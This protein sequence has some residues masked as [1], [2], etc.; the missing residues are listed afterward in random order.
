MLKQKFAVISL[1]IVWKS[2]SPFSHDRPHNSQRPSAATSSLPTTTCSHHRHSPAIP[3]L[4]PPTTTLL[5]PMTRQD[6]ARMAKM[7]P[8]TRHVTRPMCN[9]P[10]WPEEA[11][12]RHTGP[13]KGWGRVRG[14]REGMWVGRI[15]CAR[16][17]SS[18]FTTLLTIPTEP[19]PLRQT[20][21]FGTPSACVSTWRGGFWPPPTPPCIETQDGGF[22]HPPS[23]LRLAF[24]PPPALPRI[25]M[26]EGP[27]SLQ[28][29]DGGG[30]LLCHHHPVPLPRLKC[31][32][33]GCC[34]LRLMFWWEGGF[35]TPP[36]SLPRSKHGTDRCRIPLRLAFRCEGGVW[37]I[38]GPASK[39]DRRG[40]VSPSVSCFDARE[41]FGPPHYGPILIPVHTW[42]PLYAAFLLLYC[43]NSNN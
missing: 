30:V 2:L 11:K 1:R 39:H 19:F 41:V 29:Q 37:T 3:C 28:T 33:E 23:T 15:R 26:Q 17:F 42:V 22:P 5:R 36:L 8:P 13:Q 14:T 25:K 4:P 10:K 27:P 31:E 32:T 7:R 20:G 40:P 18:F 38:P 43:I 6:T 12:T 34:T 35:R 9:A 21:V 16:H 24:R